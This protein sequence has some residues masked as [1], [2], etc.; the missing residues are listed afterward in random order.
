LQELHAVTYD[1]FVSCE[2]IFRVTI[3]YGLIYFSI[4]FMIN[5]LDPAY[6]NFSIRH[7]SRY[8]FLKE[9]HHIFFFW[10]QNGTI[11]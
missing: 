3:Y 11:F 10:V 2:Q 9:W 4:I 1:F 5:N 7:R 8:Y 6:W